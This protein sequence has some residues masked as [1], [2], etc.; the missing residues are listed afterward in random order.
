MRMRRLVLWLGAMGGACLLAAYCD[1]GGARHAVLGDASLD[2]IR[3]SDNTSQTYNSGQSCEITTQSGGGGVGADTGGC[4]DVPDFTECVQCTAGSAVT[5]NPNQPTGGP[6]IQQKTSVIA[7]QNATA[8]GGF[9]LM[10]E[11][12][13]DDWPDSCSGKPQAW[14]SE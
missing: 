3:G 2:L 4:A 14:Q 1:A 8:N 6:G 13:L 10:G 7:C 11:C 12:M 5:P 9:C